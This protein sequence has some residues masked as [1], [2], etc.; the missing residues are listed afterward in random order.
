MHMYGVSTVSKSLGGVIK[1][2]TIC[3][4]RRVKEK[5]QHGRSSATFLPSKRGVA[6]SRNDFHAL[7]YGVLN[8][9]AIT[10]MLL[11]A[12]T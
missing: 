7:R 2:A 4:F 5:D 8:T 9:L 6:A 1:L 3:Q 12:S 11:I 10:A